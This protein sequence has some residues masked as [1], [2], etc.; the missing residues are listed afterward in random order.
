MQETNLIPARRLAASRQSSRLRLWTAVCACYVALL[1]V[2]YGLT[3]TYAGQS[4]GDVTGELSRVGHE[5]RQIKADIRTVHVDLVGQQT[6]LNASRAVGNQPD[7]SIL[8]AA[9]ASERGEKIFFG[10]V[11]L[12]PIVA[13]RAPEAMALD[14]ARQRRYLVHVFGYAKSQTTASRFAERLEAKGLFDNVKQVQ[15]AREPVLS[16]EAVSFRLTCRLGR[17]DRTKGAAK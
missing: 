15:T 9:I 17:I 3:Q 6:E 4:V 13:D 5:T 14:P 7:W 8:L 10:Q 2:G 1:G 11:R 16:G 12:E